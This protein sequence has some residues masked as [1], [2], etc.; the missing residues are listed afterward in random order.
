MRMLRTKGCV[1]VTTVVHIH[2]FAQAAA[3]TKEAL[4]DAVGVGAFELHDYVEF[5]S[6]FQSTLLPVRRVSE[7][8]ALRFS[9]SAAMYRT[10][11]RQPRPPT[12]SSGGA[13]PPASIVVCSDDQEMADV[14]PESALL[15]R[16]AALVLSNWVPRAGDADRPAAYAALL[17]LLGS[18]DA[19]VQLAAINALQVLI[20][21]HVLY[22]AVCGLKP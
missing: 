13:K 14:S 8:T 2:S 20:I 4:L 21:A 22:T 15:R 9:T 17:Q 19:A 10:C 6:W 11:M 16:R 1:S 7:A 5:S 3:L 12:T 18:D